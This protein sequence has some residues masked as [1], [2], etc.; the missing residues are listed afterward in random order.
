MG[1]GRSK[2]KSTIYIGPWE[3]MLAD[4]DLFHYS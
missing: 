2:E 3:E 4:H 1:S